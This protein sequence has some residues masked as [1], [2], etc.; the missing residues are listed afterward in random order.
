MPAKTPDL[1]RLTTFTVEQGA[2]WETELQVARLPLNWIRL[3]KDEYQRREG[4]QP[5]WSL[6]IRSLRELLIGLDPAVLYID[7]SSDQEDFLW[8]YPGADTEVLTAGIAAW[9]TTEVSPWDT[10]RDWWETLDPGELRFTTKPVNLLAFGR[11]LNGT[12]DPVPAM[13]QLLPSF[14]AH[15]VVAHRLPILDTPRDYILGPPDADGRRAAVLWPPQTFHDAKAGNAAVTAKITFHVETAPNDPAPRIHADLSISRFPLNPVTYVPSRGDGPPRTT[16]WLY[17]PEGFLRQQEPH[18]L[19]AAHTQQSLARETRQRQWAWTPGLARALSHLTH[20]PFPAPDKV[21]AEP[22]TASDEGKIRAYVLYSEGTKST[23]DDVDDQIA[24]PGEVEPKKARSLVHAANSG[25]VPADHLEIHRQLTPILKPRGIRPL[26]DLERVGSRTAR[27]IRPADEAGQVYSIELW[28]QSNLTV[29]AIRAAI[30]HDLG[31]TPVDT[32]PDSGTTRFRGDIDIILSTRQ[33]GIVAAGIDRKQGDTRGET[34]LQ[35]Q[36][37]KHIAQVI[38]KSDTPTAIILELE[39][40]QHFARNK[41]VDPKPALKKAFGRTGRLL[42]CLRPVKE[43]TP[44]TAPPKE[45]RRPKAPYPGTNLAVESGERAAAA[46]RDVLRQLGRI[47]VYA[48]P[49]DLPDFEQIGIWLHHVGST[50][51]PIVVRLGTDGRTVAHL[52]TDRNGTPEPIDYRDLPKALASGHG[53][54]RGPAEAQR[55]AISQFLANALGVGDAVGQDTHNRLVFARSASFRS[56]GWDWLQDKHVAPD[57]LVLPGVRLDDDQPPAR[58]FL[59]ADCPGLRIIRV[60]EQ[61]SRMEVS[62]GFGAPGHGPVRISGLFAYSDRVFYSLNPRPDQMQTPLKATKLDPDIQ[63]NHTRQVAN[64][65]PLEVFPAFLQPDDDPAVFAT[66]TSM[67]R[68]NYLHTDQATRFPVVLRL[69][70]LA[71][72]Y[73]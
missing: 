6:P 72:E 15:E 53:R 73:I 21:L 57:R 65:A 52:A 29:Q 66:F 24:A 62:R 45:G 48:A 51:I 1:M 18:T 36:H 4:V 17:A 22:A 11:R 31:L 34:N 38:G 58:T 56:W 20:L 5:H 16:L 46:V 35:H 50:R 30:E 44:P 43:F 71:D 37:A 32:S 54:L 26:A 25:F 14:L 9:A 70:E 67:M 68:R 42:Q 41:Q 49:T 23:A 13:F 8:T 12:A 60:R 64:P 39:G 61:G 2:R 3:F 63:G 27:L 28:T 33:A 55:T 69:C 47:G 59:P 7:R 19:L 10:D 40:A